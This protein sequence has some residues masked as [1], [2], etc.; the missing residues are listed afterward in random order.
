LFC[1]SSFDAIAALSGFCGI[2]EDQDFLICSISSWCYLRSWLTTSS[3]F[4]SLDLDP[5]EVV[6][7]VWGL[8]RSHN[9]F[10]LWLENSL[11]FG[12]PPLRC[13]FLSLGQGCALLSWRKILG[14]HLWLA[15]DAIGT[16]GH[17]T[18]GIGSNF[19][20]LLVFHTVIMFNLV[21]V[22]RDI[23]PRVFDGLVP[24]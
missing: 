11:S 4:A 22:L 3:F 16:D 7:L 21:F 5:V 13:P 12:I 17:W 15:E 18:V 10:P 2:E 8:Y 9:H 20:E 23:G 6:Y 24:L 1:P 19:D 14:W